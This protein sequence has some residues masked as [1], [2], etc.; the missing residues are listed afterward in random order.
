M[1]TVEDG[2]GPVLRLAVGDDVEGVSGRFFD[3]D[4]ESRAHA[5]AYDADARARLWQLSAELAGEDPL[6]GS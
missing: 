6:S 5:Q 2:V 3:R 4:R 1:S